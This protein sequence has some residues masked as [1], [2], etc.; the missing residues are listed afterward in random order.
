MEILLIPIALA[1]DAFGVALSLGFSNKYKF[2]Q[3]MLFCLSFGFFQFLFS[4]MGG[5]C[6]ELVNSY[7][8]AI[9]KLFGGIVILIVG[10][11]M[12]K[13]AMSHCD[14]DDYEDKKLFNNL[15]ITLG[16]SVSIDALVVGFTA[17]NLH[18]L[19]LIFL[20]TLLVGI[21][22]L[23]L[24]MFAVVLSM[25]L[26]KIKI[27]TKYADFLGGVLLILFGLKMIFF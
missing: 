15:Y 21:V 17:Y 24:S 10:I 23:I 12:F 16:I 1:L 22:T 18:N 8:L 9:P 27:I 13:E 7:I 3:L 19:S 14:E 11:L 20:N 5:V 2:K 6:G 4:F 25:H 26:K